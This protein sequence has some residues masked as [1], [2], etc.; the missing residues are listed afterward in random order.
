MCGSAPS[1]IRPTKWSQRGKTNFNGKLSVQ[2]AP[3]FILDIWYTHLYNATTMLTVTLWGGEGNFQLTKNWIPEKLSSYPIHPISKTAGWEPRSHR[4]RSY[5]DVLPTQSYTEA[6]WR[7]EGTWWSVV[8]KKQ[9]F[10]LWLFL[11][12]GAFSHLLLPVG[13][14][15]LSD[16]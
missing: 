14:D 5:I 1:R 11:P 6:V 4:S 7:A 8:K 15:S 3:V 9:S 12:V 13:T 10:P 2:Y 16:W